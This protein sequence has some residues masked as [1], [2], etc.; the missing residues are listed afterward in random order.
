MGYRVAD[1]F[2]IFILLM[3]FGLVGAQDRRDAVQARREV[4]NWSLVSAAYGPEDN[5]L[6]ICA[7]SGR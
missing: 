1:V 5:G 3:L 7:G 2:W 6:S 4:S